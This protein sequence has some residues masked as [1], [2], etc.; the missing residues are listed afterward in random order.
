MSGVKVLHAGTRRAGDQIFTSGGRVLG[1]TAYDANLEGALAKAYGA[2][3]QVRFEGM[4][5]RTDIGGGTGRALSA[6][7]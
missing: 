4:H 7:E 2:A 6:G 1:V 5:Y 3:G